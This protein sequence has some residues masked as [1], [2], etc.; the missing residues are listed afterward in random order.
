M[1]SHSQAAEWTLLRIGIHLTLIKCQDGGVISIMAL[2]RVD[3]LSSKEL[4]SVSAR[5]LYK[6]ERMGEFKKISFIEL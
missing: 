6:I 2:N 4:V 5:T 3:L 1:S